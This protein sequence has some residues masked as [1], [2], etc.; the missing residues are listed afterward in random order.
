MLSQNPIFGFSFSSDV[1][2]PLV[3]WSEMLRCLKLLKFISV[4]FSTRHLSSLAPISGIYQLLSV[5]SHHPDMLDWQLD[6]GGLAA[7][8]SNEEP[9]DSPSKNILGTPSQITRAN[10]S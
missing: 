7:K 2:Y 4:C 9:L 5:E 6:L 10:S 1:H 8:C 3:A